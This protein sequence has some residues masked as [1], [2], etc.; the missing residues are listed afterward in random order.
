MP[1]AASICQGVD[2]ALLHF[3][4]GEL[5]IYSMAKKFRHFELVFEN[6]IIMEVQN[7]ERGSDIT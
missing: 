3:F 7:L 2:H 5:N 6:K 4:T 1:S